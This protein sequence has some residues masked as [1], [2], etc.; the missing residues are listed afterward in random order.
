VLADQRDGAV[1]VLARLR[2][3]AD[4]SGAG[5]GEVRDDAVDRLHHQMHVDRRLDAVTA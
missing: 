1:D 5:R 2:V 3:E 4:E